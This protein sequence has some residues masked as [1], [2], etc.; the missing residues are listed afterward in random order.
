MT[1]HRENLV[2]Q[3]SSIDFSMNH[4]PSS[5]TVL[6]IQVMGLK[7]NPLKVS[8]SHGLNSKSLH[9]GNFWVTICHIC[10]SFWAPRPKEM[11]GWKRSDPLEEWA[12]L[13][14]G[15]Q[16]RHSW[17]WRGADSLHWLHHLL[18]F[19]S[20][21]FKLVQEMRIERLIPGE[22]YPHHDCGWSS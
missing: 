18:F 12:S 9:P 8:S 4:L 19:S 10:P 6:R 17:E 5:Q 1:C 3:C 11:P 16:R 15:C 13:A 21:V 14:L 20:F 2:V 7:S 22:H